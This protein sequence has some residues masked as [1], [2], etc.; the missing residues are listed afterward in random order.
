L[1]SANIQPVPAVRKGFRQE[2][3]GNPNSSFTMGVA[4]GKFDRQKWL[5]AGSQ[6]GFICVR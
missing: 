1:K 4:A 5:A 3:G 2:L 6:K